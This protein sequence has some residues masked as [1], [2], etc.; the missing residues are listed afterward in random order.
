MI[1]MMFIHLNLTKIYIDEISIST[2][3]LKLYHKV[4]ISSKTNDLVSNSQ[5]IISFL[6]YMH[7]K[8]KY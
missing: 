3:I 1:L 2:M 5:I 7:L 4:F 8:Q 6:N